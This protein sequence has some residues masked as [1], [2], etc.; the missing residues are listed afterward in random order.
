MTLKTRLILLAVLVVLF[1]TVAPYL[2]FYSLGYRVD[3][4]NQ[5]IVSTGGIYV[6]ALPQPLEV[7]VDGK[8]ASATGIFNSAVFVQNLLP[9]EHDVLIRK[10]GY[11]DYQKNLPV[12][13]KEVTKLE[14]VTLFSKSIPFE[15]LKD[16]AQFSLLR[17]KPIERFIIK[18]NSLYYSNAPEN[19]DISISQKNIPV[20]KNIVAFKVSGNDII[21][22][23][24]DGLLKNSDLEGKNTKPL[25]ETALNIDIKKSYRL[26]VFSQNIFLK[27]GNNILLFDQ[28][29]KLLGN[30]Y[31]SVKDIKLSPD[32]QKIIYFNDNE[33]L[34]YYFN[35]PPA[36]IENNALLQKVSDKISEVYW[37]N[38]DYIVFN[39]GN[40][41]MISEIDTRGNVNIISL[42]ATIPLANRED[43]SIIKPEIFFDQPTKTLYVLTQNQLISSGKILP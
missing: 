39:S 11:Y 30:F 28:E 16:V 32:G 8:I 29:T 31:S 19:A 15:S 20:I 24:L 7:L 25:S 17:Q 27:E 42:P 6:R 37:L 21:W 35:T 1:L 13:E 41:I 22:L 34:I 2:V 40:G 12:K 9:K 33:I 38:N 4:D 26:E 14:N 18:N 23:G 5:K 36:G 10:V 3:F 43:V